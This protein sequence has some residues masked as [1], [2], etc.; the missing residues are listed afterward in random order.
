MI[1]TISLVSFLIEV[2]KQHGPYLV[3][4]PLSTMT[5]RAGEFAKWAY[6][7]DHFIQ[8]QPPAAPKS[9][10]RA[11]HGPVPS[12]S[13]DVWVYH[14]GPPTSKQDQVDPHDHR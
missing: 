11:A 10:N 5:N 13:C 8:G 6:D 3:I 1:Q 2:K 9:E 14:Q 7:S 12:A 4:V